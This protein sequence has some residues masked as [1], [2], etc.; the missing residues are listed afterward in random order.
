MHESTPDPKADT[1]DMKQKITEV[2]YI[3]DR[4]VESIHRLNNLLMESAEVTQNDNVAEFIV[5][6]NVAARVGFIDILSA[7]IALHDGD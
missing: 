1:R 6:L 3:Y 4:A 2:T 5:R 7:E